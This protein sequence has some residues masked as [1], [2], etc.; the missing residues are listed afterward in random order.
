MARI[1]VPGGTG[2]IG[3]HLVPRL[4]ERGDEVVVLTRGADGVRD[5][6]RLVHW[7]ASTLGDWVEV[8]DGAD[9]IVHLAGKRVDCRPTRRNVDE[10]IR[11]RVA[12]V[13]VVGKALSLVASP[14]PVWVQST[15]LAIHGDGGDA[16]IEDDTVPSG[17]GPRQMVQVALAWEHAFAAATV[18]VQRGVVLRVG[19]CIGGEG[20]PA[21]ARLG[22]LARMRLGGAV[23]GGRQWFSWIGLED[24]L[25]GFLRAIDDAGMVG[26]YNL[27]APNPV[28]NAEL[29][30]LVRE[31]VGV[32]FGLASPAW[33]T[34]LGAPML[35]SDAQLALTGRRAVP[36]RLLAEG[37]TFTG[38]DLPPVLAE[39]LA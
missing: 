24:L 31:A 17:I 30:R 16:V 22:Q 20:D 8:L 36:S 34:K 6:V 1:V 23:G 33:L 26:T 27:T 38:P 9:A 11:S 29:M 12:S 5:G 28:T 10:L 25:A 14:P 21:T 4:V 13:A 19:V 37:F 15:T 7:D 18:G 35:G 32:R 3:T 2:F 39:V